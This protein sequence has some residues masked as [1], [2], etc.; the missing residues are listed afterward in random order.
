MAKWPLTG[1]LPAPKFPAL[2]SLRTKPESL[3]MGEP[4]AAAQL[5]AWRE[6]MGDPDREPMPAPYPLMPTDEAQEV[7]RVLNRKTLPIVHKYNRS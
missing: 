2:L 7:M 5:R 3:Y 4:T 1:N 6:A